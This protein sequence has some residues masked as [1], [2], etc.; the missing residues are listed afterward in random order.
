MKLR[1]AALSVVLA[2][3]ALMPRGVL[4]QSGQPPAGSRRLG[5]VGQN[6]PNPFNP[7]TRFHFTV[8]DGAC[9]GERHRVTI[10]IYNILSQLV[11]IPVVEGS[12]ATASGGEPIENMV[13]E[14]GSY[15]AFWNGKHQGTTREAASGVYLARVE[16]DGKS[17]GVIRMFLG[18]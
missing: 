3:S 18:K 15:T 10:R 13:L 7:V 1:W 9:A 14:C 17:V 11:S 5:S 8:G 4:A 12:S 16:I 6:Y 2:L